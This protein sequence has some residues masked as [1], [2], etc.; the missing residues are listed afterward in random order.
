MIQ[1][2]ID[3]HIQSI[4]KQI[5]IESA[6]AQSFIL[7]AS[8]GS[9]KTTRLPPA[10]LESIESFDVPVKKIIVLVPKRIAA[11]SAAKR[12]ASERHWTLG[13]KIGFEVR[14]ESKSS[15]E[16]RLVFM[17]TGYFL[18][19]L[20][21]P[22][23]QSQIGWLI[24]DEFHERTADMDLA[25][26]WAREKKILE[27][28]LQI[29]VMSATLDLN[30]LKN[31]LETENVYDVAHPPFP[32]EITYSTKNQALSLND[33]FLETL[34]DT[35]QES[36]S[37]TTGHILV[38]LPGLSEIRR[39]FQ[40][41]SKSFPSFEWVQ[42]HGQ[43]NL[44]EQSDILEKLQNSKHR[45]VILSTNVAE[46]SLTL[47]N[48]FCVIDSGL[49]RR[50]TTSTKLG[51]HALETVRISK[52][53][54]I[55]RAGRSN[56]Q[57]AGRTY[58]LWHRTD[59]LS[60]P[61]SIKAEILSCDFLD[62]TLKAAQL[63]KGDPLQIE[64]L[65]RPPMTALQT[66]IQE[67]IRLKLLTDRW[68]LTI[69]GQTVLEVPLPVL[70]A[71]AFVSLSL[72]GYQREASALYANLEDAPRRS[73]GP[74]VGR[75]ADSSFDSSSGAG[76][77]L[78]FLLR[79]PSLFSTR[80]KSEQLNS[81]SFN[82]RGG[83]TA[84]IGLDLFEKLKTWGHFEDSLRAVL[85]MVSRN[86]LFKRQSKFDLSFGGSGAELSPGSS[87]RTAERLIGYYFALRGHQNTKGFDQI[88]YAL[89]VSTPT[90]LQIVNSVDANLI[91]NETQ[92][93]FQ[94]SN[95]RFVRIQRK[96]LGAFSISESPP[97]PI[98]DHEANQ[99]WKDLL[100]KQF[101][102]V[103][104][105]NP[106]YTWIQ[107]RLQ[108]IAKNLALNP[109]FKTQFGPQ[110][111]HLNLQYP[112]LSWPTDL[113]KYVIQSVF[114][115]CSTLSEAVQF[116]I[117]SALKYHQEESLSPLLMMISQLP[118]NFT[119]PNGRTAKIDYID[120]KAPIISSRLQD[121]FGIKKNPEIL[122]GLMNIACEMLA[123]NQ[124]PVQVT[125]D[126]VQFWTG[127]YFE[128]KKE[129]K[130]RY[131]KHDWPED[132]ANSISLPKKKTFNAGQ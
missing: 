118:T 114:L 88:E 53:S 52:F 21:D 131:P 20:N 75:N 49:E 46:S 132:P 1:L 121:F 124:R 47:P 23:F 125:S 96:K 37:K 91:E 31:F 40:F 41:L 12:I 5:A 128:L 11:T 83:L 25:L 117:P 63:F 111:E 66:S 57:A 82:N 123:P 78:D 44:D 48:T 34:K 27:G 65:T 22:V 94:E 62:L 99:M 60:M 129:L 9:G 112:L 89:E 122:D 64:W 69:L 76:T 101:S 50:Q 119:F 45:F 29:I 30:P 92:I 113:Q 6:S 72:L 90:L 15:P 19:K 43:L 116:D 24:F 73:L 130:G 104:E 70:D 74:G 38:F 127:G 126:L 85:F 87:V 107:N 81:I 100:Q 36:I 110:L 7:T 115:S 93:D 84:E 58:R 105:K 39:S 77:D 68:K 97:Q 61:E 106:H 16:T 98:S 18:K 17:T 33:V 4:L 59:E 42:F 54:A 2:P 79:A 108:F 67:L 32:L 3:S 28:N 10:L 86:R 35:L 95:N 56:R 13:Q 55:Q 51:F 102:I 80:K 8:P 71:L 120:E 26:A 14:F 103:M 109:K